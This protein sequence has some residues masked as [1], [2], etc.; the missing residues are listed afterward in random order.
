MLEMANNF[1]TPAFLK[2]KKK[3]QII[4]HEKVP[5][6]CVLQFL[7]NGMDNPTSNVTRKKMFFLSIDRM[8][9][10]ML[11]FPEWAVIVGSVPICH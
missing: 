9:Q 4:P 10:T 11:H 8:M 6:F 3:G 5:P 7:F 1:S 2:K